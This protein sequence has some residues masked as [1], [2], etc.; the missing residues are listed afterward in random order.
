LAEYQRA[1]EVTRQRLYYEMIE[2]I[3]GK[4]KGTTLVDH[5]LRNFLPMMNLQGG[6]R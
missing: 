3:F 5:N 4:E 2:E 1:P 6:T